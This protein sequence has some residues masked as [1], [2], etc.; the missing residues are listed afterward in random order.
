MNSLKKRIAKYTAAEDTKKMGLYPYFRAISSNQ[1]TSVIIKGREVLM[2][3]SNSYLG[4]T[5]HPV[6]KEAAK[7]AA[8]RAAEAA[9]QDRTKTGDAGDAEN[10]AANASNSEGAGG[11][12][13]DAKP[14]AKPQ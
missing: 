7:K 5:N 14:K 6:V 10:E 2:F 11:A 3:G 9:T 8:E 12:G 13:N 1:D 4:L